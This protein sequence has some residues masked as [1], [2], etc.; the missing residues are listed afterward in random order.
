MV[1]ILQ[2]NREYEVM[3]KLVQCEAKMQNVQNNAQKPD[4]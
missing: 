4:I 3:W 1:G 2:F